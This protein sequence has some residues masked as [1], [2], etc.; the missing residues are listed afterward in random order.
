[1]KLF[2]TK[3]H[4]NCIIIIYKKLEQLLDEYGSMMYANIVSVSI[5]SIRHSEWT[6]FPQTANT[7]TNRF[8]HSIITISKAA[9]S[10]HLQWCHL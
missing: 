8:S 9:T 10:N 2:S 5:E 1:M 7:T 3:K 6:T 4:V